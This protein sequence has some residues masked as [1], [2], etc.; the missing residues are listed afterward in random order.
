MWLVVLLLLL[1]LL[2]LGAVQYRY[3]DMRY[4]AEERRVLAEASESNFIVEHSKFVKVKGHRI[5]V[6]WNGAPTNK[7]PVYV[8]VHGLGGQAVQFE[9]ILQGLGSLPFIAID[10]PGCGQSEYRARLGYGT[11]IMAGMI[12]AVIEHV[13]GSEARII[14]VGHSMGCVLAARV[15]MSRKNVQSVVLICP[16]AALTKGEVKMLRVL[17]H[18][19]TTLFDVLRR[20]DRGRLGAESPSVTRF[21]GSNPSGAVKQRQMLW[22]LQS[23]SRTFQ[24]FVRGMRLLK[25][26]EWGS[27]HQPV[28]LIAAECVRSNGN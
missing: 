9:D 7:R 2:L 19:P 16:K 14:L 4:S 13:V 17:P 11:E 27:L 22:N 20:L 26:E 18:L 8:F 15:A 5:R 10:L 1:L 12:D 6:V 24:N 3:I 21:L 23:E 25:A 28:T